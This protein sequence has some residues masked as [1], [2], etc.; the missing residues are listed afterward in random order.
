MITQ[1]ALKLLIIAAPVLVLGL[2]FGVPTGRFTGALLRGS[3]AALTLVAVLLAL[4]LAGLP[5]LWNALPLPAGAARGLPA[6]VVVVAE[7]CVKLVAV[8]AL[9]RSDRRTQPVGWVQRGDTERTSRRSTRRLGAALGLGFAT[10][11]HL[12]FLGTTVPGMLLR[13]A[14]AGSIHTL[15][16]AI[17][18][19]AADDRGPSPTRRRV[20]SVALITVGHLTYNLLLQGLDQNLTVW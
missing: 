6:L 8:I 19:A 12:L 18:V 13:I 17:Y 5:R 9:L 4:R 1:L 7:E 3:L 10:V 20:L 11:E 2:V 14:G 15:S 16:G